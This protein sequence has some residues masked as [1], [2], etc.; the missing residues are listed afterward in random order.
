MKLNS[1]IA[2]I[3]ATVL[4]GEAM[5]K[6]LPVL[7]VSFP[8]NFSKNMDYIQGSMS[9]TDTDGNVI[10]LPA[11][12][13]TRGATA[14]NYSM[15]PSFNM[16]LRETD[17]TEIDSALCGIRSCSSWI[18]DAMAIDRI[19][20]RNR[21]CTDTWNAFS[22]L[23][24]D[25]QFDGRGASDG[26]FVEVYINDDY[27]GIYCLTDRVNRKLLDLKKVKIN[28]DSTVSIR[29]VLY[30]HGT[31][32]IGDQS[33]TGIFLD[34]TICVAAWHDA[35][36]LTEPEDYGCME[37]WRPLLDM[38][39]YR[40]DYQQV[41]ENFYLENIADYTLLVMAFSLGDNW[42]N[43]NHYLSIRNIQKD[44]NKARLVYSPWDM[45]A[46]IGGDYKGSYYDG[47]YEEGFPVKDIGKNAVQPFSTCLRE[48]EF[49]QMMKK[50]WEELREGALSIEAVAERLQGYARLFVE[51]GA[52]Q[53]QYEHFQTQKYKPCLVPDL[54]A[55]VNM[56]VQ[57]YQSRF[58]QMDDYFGIDPTSIVE[59]NIKYTKPNTTTYNLLGQ[60]TPPRNTGIMISNGEKA[61]SP[62]H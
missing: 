57:W 47:K 1:L 14:L 22:R 34:S 6:S 62:C 35:W 38:Y 32:S 36:E 23:P 15:K 29:G 33:T 41:A 24:Y 58:Q 12:F 17:G 46:S 60:P 20:M 50:R 55:E 18:L 49:K 3:I 21:V 11:K 10:S 9:L 43:K 7:R 56:V 61:L 26:R 5:A 45:D 51:S 19:N 8:G 4:G 39:Q 16:K 54:Y 40:Q 25:T 42:G 2:L 48:P 28:E 31:T 27:K 44:G 37:A 52:W 59:N 13:K 53:R 30:K